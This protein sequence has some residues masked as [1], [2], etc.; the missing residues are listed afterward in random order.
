MLRFGLPLLILV[1]SLAATLGVSV[2]VS[3]VAAEHSRAQFEKQ[4]RLSR[5][6]VHMRLKD[7]E[8]ALRGAQGLYAASKSVE[9]QEWKAYVAGMT[10]SERF[11]GLRG[12]SFIA[13]V[14]D[15]QR[16]DFLNITRQDNSPEFEIRPAGNRQEFRPIKYF[17]PANEGQNS[18]GFDTAT[19]SESVEAQN[20]ARDTG[21]VALSARFNLR[22]VEDG[23]NSVVIYLPI[24]RNGR[25]TE[26]VEQRRAAIEGWVAAPTR[27]GA[28]LNDVTG[29]LTQGVDLHIE[30]ASEGRALLL[31][32]NPR[33]D[34]SEGATLF[35]CTE[36][37]RFGGRLW[38]LN[39]AATPEFR[40]SETDMGMIALGV[41]L[42]M[43]LLLSAT[44]QGLTLTRGRALK[45]A[46]EMTQ[47][48]RDS[49]ER[50]RALI[51]KSSDYI[52]VVDQQAVATYESPAVE[53][54]TG[55]KPEELVGRPALENV[56]PDDVAATGAAL[57]SGFAEPG[58]Q[59]SAVYR[60]KHKNGS[61]RTYE[62]TGRAMVNDKGE[63]EAIINTRDV[64]E[65]E[66]ALAALRESEAAQ[67]K[68]AQMQRDLLNALPAHVAFLD[69][70]GAILDVNEAW[71]EF[72]RNNGLAGK[73]FCVGV[74]YL[75]LCRNAS[76]ADADGGLA[77]AKGIQQVIAGGSSLF[78]FEYPCHSP[79]QQR[80]FRLMAAPLNMGGA[81]G[82]VVMH[83]DITE[84]V[85]AQQRMAEYHAEIGLKNIELDKALVKANE[86]TQLKSEF[87]ANMSHEIRTP[88]NGVIGMTGLLLETPLSREQREFAEVIRGSGE[89]L[90]CIINDILDFSK[91]EAG[92][93]T[94]EPVEFDL[95]DSVHEVAELL[96]KQ[97]QDKGIELLVRYDVNCPRKIVADPG[98]VRQVILNLVGNAVKFTSVGHVLVDVSSKPSTRQDHVLVRVAITDTG[99][100]IAPE[101]LSLLFQK[102]SQADASTTR[103]FGGTG[104][105]LAISRQLV[106]LMGGQVGVNSESGKGSTF[107]FELDVPARPG[108]P[109]GM[110][111]KT[112]PDDFRVIVVD[113]DEV[114]RRV[115]RQ[116]CLSLGMS[117]ETAESGMEA[118]TKMRAAAEQGKP[119]AMGLLDMRMPI[120]DG[121]QLARNIKKDAR[122]Q[123][124]RLV[125]VSAHARPDDSTLPV[126]MVE[127]VLTKP[128]RCT[129]LISV[130]QRMFQRD[131][132]T[133]TT[134]ARIKPAK[135]VAVDGVEG[136]RVLVA[137]DNA[138]N[139]KLAAR[140]LE[141]LGC[142]VDIAANGKEAV[143]MVGAINY[144]LVLMDCQMPELDGY[145]ATQ[146]I[147]QIVVGRHLPIVAMTANAMEGDREK[148]LASG[149]DDY[150]SKPM[151]LESVRA[152]ISR[153][154]NLQPA[155]QT[156]PLHASSN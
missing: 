134:T 25:K 143:Q 155:V 126:G 17:E 22:T 48:L 62:S 108:C 39:Y 64:T 104:L 96:A 2:L 21:A 12:M 81:L 133:T 44:V 55:F 147:R 95:Q 47:T 70:K 19:I 118:L 83:I 97:A 3:S 34:H 56:H 23:D 6:A 153:W 140:M 132:K 129:V 130:I 58:V 121:G 37:I 67:R 60:M 30:D 124:T 8:L 110:D 40:S 35:S 90:L 68:A 141:K 33:R 38:H 100:G 27:I 125:I 115:L 139:Q 13:A 119:F 78:V 138:V 26:T 84:R 54:L 136:K 150:V 32:S 98:R 117:C 11:P 49:Q 123:S 113:D 53:T 87:L 31:D 149:M 41:G 154:M 107:F 92:K 101:K 137:E 106:E 15:S 145:Q 79:Q 50:F 109:C 46:R 51:E 88:M 148:C 120:M 71:R 85:Q 66:A 14:P 102:F 61:Y 111:C 142:R 10:L 89:A 42:I 82:A 99:I 28:L 91:I 7:S 131:L 52:T 127:A 45:L 43:S 74:N 156:P 105:G 76:G 80:W 72:G 69:H 16:A 93:L 65:R 86:A 77:A 73:E 36:E 29:V 59:K 151:K 5:D 20:R 94:L 9:R 57:A 146:Q 116:L 18:I 152:V 75:E 128:V 63:L 4:A 1:L 114:S 144:D 103:H 135:A 24:Y 122:L 112:L